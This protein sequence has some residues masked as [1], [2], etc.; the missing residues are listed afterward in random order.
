VESDE[1]YDTCSGA[2]CDLGEFFVLQ[3]NTPVIWQQCPVVSFVIFLYSTVLYFIC[4][5]WSNDLQPL[6][7]TTK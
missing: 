5:G 4:G 1:V 2:F 6:D 3:S 7:V